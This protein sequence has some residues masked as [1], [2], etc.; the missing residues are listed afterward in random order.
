VTEQLPSPTGILLVDKS[1]GYTSMD[2]CAVVR[3]RLRRAGPHVPKRLKVGHAGTLDPMATGLLVVLVGRA[4]RLCEALMADTKVYETAIDLAHASTTDDAEGEVS[5][6]P[7]PAEAPD[8]DLV[9]RTIAQSFTGVVMQRPPAYSAISVGGQRAYDL[10]RAGREVN[11]EPRP[12]RVDAFEVLEYRWPV[13]KARITCGKG[14]YIRALARD[15]GRA[16]G[17]GGML[18]ELRRTRSG[19]YTVDQ[20]RTLDQL[21]DPLTQ[22]DLLPPPGPPPAPPPR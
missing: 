14:T 13:L 17:V 4:T 7:P 2:V 3:S 11:L 6:V 8:L 18:T 5:E 15:L 9:R 12:V 19:A 10:A 20:A 1:R 16:L 21:P 22:A